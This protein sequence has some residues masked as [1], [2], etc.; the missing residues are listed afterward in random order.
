MIEAEGLAENIVAPF[1][2]PMAGWNG[3]P[4]RTGAGSRSL[5]GTA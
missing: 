1:N 5:P 4:A 3:K 2:T